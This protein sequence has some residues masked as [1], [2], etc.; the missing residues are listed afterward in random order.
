V[1]DESRDKSELQQ[2]IPERDSVVWDQ[3]GTILS[4]QKK[5]TS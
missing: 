4:K 1:D 2:D 3:L 5:L